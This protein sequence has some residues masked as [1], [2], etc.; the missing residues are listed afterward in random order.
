MLN[1]HNGDKTRLGLAARSE[2]ESRFLKSRRVLKRAEHKTAAKPLET[3]ARCRLPPGR[4]AGK[5]QDRSSQAAQL[6]P[7]S[8]P[9]SAP[10]PSAATA[11]QDP[12]QGSEANAGPRPSP[13]GTWAPAGPCHSTAT[14]R[15]GDGSKR[16]RTEAPCGPGSP[17]FPRKLFRAPRCDPLPRAAASPGGAVERFSSP[18]GGGCSPRG[19]APLLPRRLLPLPLRCS[20]ARTLVPPSPPLAG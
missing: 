14:E 11:D 4:F 2:H 13:G 5:Q 16:Y 8:Q 9:P 7:V 10:Q 18:L 17:P 15:G 20:S 3:P 19:T 6:E 1:P 12:A